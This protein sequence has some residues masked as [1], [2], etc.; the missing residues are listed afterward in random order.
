MKEITRTVLQASSA[1]ELIQLPV[2]EV[3]VPV[4]LQFRYCVCN[5]E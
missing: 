1:Q 5:A 3:D 4:I 2:E